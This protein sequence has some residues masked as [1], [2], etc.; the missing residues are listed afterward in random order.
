MV[1]A[2]VSSADQRAGLDRQVARL[3]SWVTGRAR[4]AQA[5]RFAL[6]PTAEQ[7]RVLARQFGG[8]RRAYNWAVRELKKD[9]DAYHAGL[10]DPDARLSGN[11]LAPRPPDG[12]SPGG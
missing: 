5:F 6:D 12:G 3:T 11:G 1:C 8:R 2:R 9:I 10:A 7:A 4:R